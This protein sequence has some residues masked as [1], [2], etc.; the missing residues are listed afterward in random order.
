MKNDTPLKAWRADAPTPAVLL[1][2]VAFA[3]LPYWKPWL[4]AAT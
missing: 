3:E 1:E 2:I 4:T